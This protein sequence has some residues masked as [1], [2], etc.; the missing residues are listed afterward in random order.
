MCL[1]ADLHC[2]KLQKEVPLTIAWHEARVLAPTL[3]IIYFKDFPV[4]M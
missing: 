3:C 2:K 4:I 1:K